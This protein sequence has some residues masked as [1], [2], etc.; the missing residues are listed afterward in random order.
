MTLIDMHAHLFLSS[1][2]EE[3]TSLLLRTAEIYGID[4]LCIS[5]LAGFFPREEEV[6]EA[7]RA[8]YRFAKEHPS[9]VSAYTYVSPELENAELTLR[10]GIEDHAAIGAKVWVSEKCD[11]PRMNA[12]AE[13]LI[14][15]RK[16]LLIHAFQKSTGQVAKES[17]A[18]NVRAL[19][20]RYP[21]LSIVM[22]HAGG[23][24]Y[25]G[26]EAVRDLP[27]VLADVSGTTPKRGEVEYA[28]R[29]LGEDRV[30]F[31]SDLPCGSFALPLGKVLEASVSEA[32]REKILCKNALR[33]FRNFER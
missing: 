19:A 30:L 15:Y 31:G 33:L 24:C 1:D 3:Q 13:C 2:L 6:G 16:P 5:S 27:N 25:A 28:V 32:A 17:T 4:R 22:A 9:L 21:E 12:I 20:R 10:R 18:Q 29:L 7:N 11:S 8:A 26:V 23:N 14:S